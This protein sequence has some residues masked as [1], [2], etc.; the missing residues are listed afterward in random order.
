MANLFLEYFATPVESEYLNKMVEK[1]SQSLV[2]SMNKLLTCS[3]ISWQLFSNL[4]KIILQNASA[5]EVDIT[6]GNTEAIVLANVSVTDCKENRAT[7]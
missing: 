1:N 2:P 7:N 4:G 6:E 5:N 3:N